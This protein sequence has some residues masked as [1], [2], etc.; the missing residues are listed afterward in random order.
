MKAHGQDFK[1]RVKMNDFGGQKKPKIE[2]GGL[3]FASG[4]AFDSKSQPT[5]AKGPQKRPRP[6]EDRPKS[7]K[8]R[9]EAKNQR[10]PQVPGA[11]VDLSSGWSAPLARPVRAYPGGF[12]PGK[13]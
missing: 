8:K 10:T 5:E 1:Q 4:D 12:R 9:V 2:P 7:A 11:L 13:S 6:A 3:N